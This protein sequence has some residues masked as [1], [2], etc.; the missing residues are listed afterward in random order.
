MQSLD[1]TKHPSKSQLK[2]IARFANH[3]TDGFFAGAIPPGGWIVGSEWQKKIRAHCNAPLRKISVVFPPLSSFAGESLSRA[4]CGVYPERSEWASTR[5]EI[6][7][8]MIEESLMLE[9]KHPCHSDEGDARRGIPF[10]HL[11]LSKGFL[12]SF[13]MTK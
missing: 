3:V 2:R 4:S 1:L 6:P 5:E 13:E 10:N 12:T 7:I 9:S 11:R 8:W